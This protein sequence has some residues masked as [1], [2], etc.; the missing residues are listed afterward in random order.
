[1]DN[2]DIQRKVAHMLIEWNPLQLTEAAH[3][4][5]ANEVVEALQ[6]TF[7]PSILGNQIQR[8]YEASFQKWL[9]IEEC[10]TTARKL[11]SLKL[12][13]MNYGD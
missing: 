3:K 10:I 13:E 11:I 8:I 12:T 6:Q 9:P 5:Q 7:D 4:T 1:M 2:G